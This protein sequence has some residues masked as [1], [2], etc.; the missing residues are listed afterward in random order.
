MIDLMVHLTFQISQHVRVKTIKFFVPSG[1]S[2][3]RL[4]HNKSKH[5]RRNSYVN[6][7]VELTKKIRLT[8]EIYITLQLYTV[9]DVFS[10]LR[11]VRNSR[12][13]G[14]NLPKINMK[15]WITVC[16]FYDL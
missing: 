2:Y 5:Y 11:I 6:L 9:C 1:N 7:T 14:Q 12:I 8:N 3:T 4:R 15:S 10:K 16:F 13:R